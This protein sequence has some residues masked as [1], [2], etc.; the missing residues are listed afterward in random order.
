MD[1]RAR[2][3]GAN[4]AM[5]REVNQ[6]IEELADTFELDE[7]KIEF[8][9]ECGRAAC[10]EQ[11]QLTAGE[12]GTIHDDPHL[13]VMYPGHHAPEVEFVVEQRGG[14]DVVRKRGGSPAQLAEQ[15]DPRS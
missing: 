7:R 12:Y 11:I 8:V 5:F 2:R 10:L 13:F 15:S 4:E 14:Y 1:E 9:C 3:I 6:R